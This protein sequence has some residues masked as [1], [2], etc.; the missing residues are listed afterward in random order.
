MNHWLLMFRPDT[1]SIVTDKGLV[2]VRAEHRRRFE[3]IDDGDPFIAFI[4][5]TAVLDGSGK[6]VGQPFVATDPV[7]GQGSDYPHRCRVTF[8]RTGAAVPVKNVLWGLDAWG[9]LGHDLRTHPSNMLFCYGGFMQIP[10][11]DY[12]RLLELVVAR[13][14]VK[15]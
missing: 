2:G 4:S 12:Q 7:F 3:Q 10:P 15:I 1:Y 9:R 8:E 13:E 14:A 11:S 5:K 6:F